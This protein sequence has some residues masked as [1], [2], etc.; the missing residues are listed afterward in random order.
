[1]KRIGFLFAINLLVFS[2]YGQRESQGEKQK[3]NVEVVSSA[4]VEWTHLNPARGDAGPQAG[5]LWGNRTREGKTGFLVK[6]KDGFSSPPHIHNVSYRGIVLNGMVHNDDEN[7]D[8][9]WLP[10]GS[11][12]TQPAGQPHIAAAE[13]QYNLAY[14]EIESGLYW[15]FLQKRQL[16]IGKTD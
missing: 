14:I 7:A 15:V 5:N 12:W 9:M 1:M 11:Y 2:A 4:E 6:F 3:P 8:K 16:T 10:A 13:G